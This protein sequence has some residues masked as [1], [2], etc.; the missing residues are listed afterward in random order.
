[1]D[2]HLTVARAQVYS[3][4]LPSWHK[5]IAQV[6]DINHIYATGKFSKAKKYRT[7]LSPG[8]LAHVA[9]DYNI[10]PLEA[11]LPEPERETSSIREISGGPAVY[12][13]SKEFKDP[14]VHIDLTTGFYSLSLQ[15]MDHEALHLKAAAA[16]AINSAIILA[17]EY[18]F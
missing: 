4:A 11:Y 6:A 14:R 18:L 13:T 7:L 5:S 15:I 16:A 3:L 9:V 12:L 8:Q 2:P 17:E 1:M 10:H